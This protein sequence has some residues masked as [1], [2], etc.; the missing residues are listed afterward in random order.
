M[1]ELIEE[2]E[3]L[4]LK[5][6]LGYAIESEEAAK[7]YYTELSKNAPELVGMKFE[8][9]AREEELHKK[10][11]LTIYRE[12]YK[13]ELYKIPE[14]LPPL[15]SPVKVKTITSLIGA[16]ENALWNEHN[17]Y[18]VY[19]YLAAKEKKHR[20]LFT[21]LAAM[22]KGH[23]ELLRMEKDTYENHIMETPNVKSMTLIDLW[24][25]AYRTH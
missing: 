9:L 16:L 17:A 7:K 21:Y 11:V 6:I 23:Y 20:D 5:E 10:T 13:N 19:T 1:M 25:E 2:L 8:N 15:E 14:N 22:E 12:L 3:K 4:S 18:R 24:L